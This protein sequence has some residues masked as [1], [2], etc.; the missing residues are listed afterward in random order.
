MNIVGAAFGAFLVIPP[1]LLGDVFELADQVE[2]LADAHVVEKLLL[3]ALA[4]F[5]A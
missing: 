4:E 2:P 5:I 1:Q 3:H